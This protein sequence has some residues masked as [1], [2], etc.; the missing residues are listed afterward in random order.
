MH[1][2]GCIRR[3]VVMAMM[4]GCGLPG[5][6]NFAGEAMVLFGAWKVYQGITALACWG[7]LI[8]GAVYMLRA[9]RNNE[10]FI[11]SHGEF[12]PGILERHE[13]IVAS[14]DPDKAPPDRVASEVVNL[15]NPLYPA[16][17][18]RVRANRI[19]RRA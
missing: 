7:A 3:N 8:I 2:I 16:E 6:A 15:R 12:G 17:R 13:A 19:G 4:A 1:V 14:F 11:V 18:D 5:F 9:I 10:L